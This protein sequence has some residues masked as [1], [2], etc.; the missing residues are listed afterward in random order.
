MSTILDLITFT[1]ADERVGLECYSRNPRLCADDYRKTMKEIPNLHYFFTVVRNT[2]SDQ[3]I[4]S[5]IWFRIWCVMKAEEEI[6]LSITHDL[7]KK[8]PHMDDREVSLNRNPG[9]KVISHCFKVL[10]GLISSA[11]GF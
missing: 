4:P 5:M 10:H 7:L 8:I 1:V 6:G 3:S 11:N 2:Y 9:P